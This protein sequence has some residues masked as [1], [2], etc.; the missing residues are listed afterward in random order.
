MIEAHG[1]GRRGSLL[2]FLFLLFLLLFVVYPSWTVLSRSVY[3]KG[4]PG[5]GN[6]LALL[7]RPH[8][9]QIVRQSVL[10]AG[11]VA[12]CATALGACIAVTVF[13]TRLPLRGLFRAAAVLPLIIPG[14]VSSI[15]FLFL[16]GR[17]GLITY[18]LLKLDLAI[19]TWKSVFL[20]QVMD[21]ATI[22]F[23]LVSA[24]LL[25]MDGRPEDA[26]R[27]LGASETE[28]FRT[29]TLPLLRP[30]LLA[31][32]ILIF[33]RSMADFGTPLFLGGRFATLAS[34]SYSQLI[35]SYNLEM[36]SAMNTLLLLI[37]L[38]AFLLFRRA[39]E[40]GERTRQTAE[41]PP[42]PFAFPRPLAALL[43]G[44][45]RALLGVRPHDPRFGAARRLHAP[46]G[47]ELRPHGAPLSERISEGVARDAEHP[48][49]RLLR[50]AAGEPR[51]HDRGLARR[52]A[53][54]NGVAHARSSGDVAVR[55]PGDVSGS[56]VYSGVQSAADHARGHVGA[57]ADPHRGQGASPGASLRCKRAQPPGR[58][59]GGRRR[60]ARRRRVRG[61]FP[62]R[63]PARPPGDDRHGAPR[64]RRYGADRRRA[65]LHR[66]AGDEAALRGRL[67]GG[68]QGGDRDGGGAFGR[69]ALPLCG[70]HGG[71]SPLDEKGKERN[72]G[73]QGNWLRGERSDGAGTSGRFEELRRDGGPLPFLALRALRDA[74]FA[75]GTVGVR[76]DDRAPHR[77][78]P[79]GAGRGARRAPRARHHEPPPEGAQPRDG[80]SELRALSPP[81][82]L[83]EHRLRTA[84]QTL[85]RTAGARGG[86]QGA[87][88]G[89]ARRVRPARRRGTLRRAA[90]AR[91][92]GQG[93]G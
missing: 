43:C 10:V 2:P 66:L 45:L 35:G 80:L 67:R 48:A 8:L 49:L 63:P 37:C 22:A 88:A 83:R 18:K 44:R 56:G 13:R 89:T 93:A 68:L 84:P 75:A 6:L 91:R 57:R 5:L 73:Y 92:V 17:N 78:R 52:P 74:L 24:S 1:F 16:F 82:R 71:H 9:F 32:G 77:R 62:D 60:H 25:T 53:S 7:E 51:R 55:H 40:A 41:I 20:I 27:T 76:Q 87:G 28:V 50:R 69:H 31:A 14:F 90:A 46:P 4:V 29:V 61:V 11:G 30:G 12:F 85:S 86:R 36:A 81:G 26:A 79:A 47:R 42:E 19:Y 3:V 70:G 15:S 23:L 65:D 54:G 34:A 39:Q 33:M 59:G 58:F 72:H 21:F 64:V 38:V